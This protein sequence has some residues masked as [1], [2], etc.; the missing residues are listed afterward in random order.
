MNGR[1]ILLADDEPHIL[2]VLA[3]VLRQNGFRVFA[4]ADGEEAFELALEQ[5]LDLVIADVQ[6]PR[7]DGVGLARRLWGDARTRAIP[8]LFLTAQTGAEWHEF[9]PNVRS[10]V[11]KPFSPRAMVAEVRR[12]M[13]PS[14]DER[15]REAA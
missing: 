4:A 15:T 9:T 1:T 5:R 6:M 10:V 2:Q 12:W 8:V 11:T 3:V 14:P 13:R 7:L